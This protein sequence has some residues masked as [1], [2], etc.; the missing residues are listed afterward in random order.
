VPDV[1]W[2][3]AARDDLRSIIDY[4]ASRNPAAALKLWEEIEAKVR[5]LAH[6]PR[7]YRTGRVAGTREMVVR[8]NYIVVYAET[9]EVRHGA[10]GRPCTRRRCGRRRGRS[11]IVP[12]E[13]TFASRVD[14]P[15]RSP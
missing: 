11:A 4:I 7:L 1:E 5:R 6:E 15:R 12:R 13:K 3:Q 10:Q 14:K 8:P 2:R 9:P